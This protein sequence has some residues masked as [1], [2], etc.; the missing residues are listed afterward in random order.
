MSLLPRFC[1]LNTESAL[2]SYCKNQPDCLTGLCQQFQVFRF[3][4]QG[5]GQARRPSGN[6]VP[7]HLGGYGQANP[8]IDLDESLAAGIYAV[9]V[10]YAA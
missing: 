10:A 2:E 6:A 3:K 8:D 1:F 7:D 4:E 9:L 5:F